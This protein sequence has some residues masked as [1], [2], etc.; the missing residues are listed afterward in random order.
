[1]SKQPKALAATLASEIIAAV[2]KNSVGPG[3]LD[4]LLRD[5]G[6]A[7]LLLNPFAA[8]TVKDGKLGE[9][10]AIP[11]HIGPGGRKSLYELNV[12]ERVL[13]HLLVSPAGAYFQ[14]WE[15]LTGKLAV[16]DGDKFRRD[17]RK[18]TGELA[19]SDEGAF[20][21]IDADIGQGEVSFET[22]TLVWWAWSFYAEIR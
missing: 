17:V 5:L 10:V 18:L 19:A 4:R 22:M 8:T 15:R 11:V 6:A 14:Y 13:S 20:K 7:P 21:L 1:M 9:L 2:R 12:G 16:A 3:G